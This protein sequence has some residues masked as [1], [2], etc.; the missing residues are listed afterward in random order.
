MVTNSC[1]M[2]HDQI[3]ATRDDYSS[4]LEIS[5]NYMFLPSDLI[6]SKIKFNNDNNLASNKKVL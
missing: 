2:Y 3:I 5:I 1:F 6:S 4:I